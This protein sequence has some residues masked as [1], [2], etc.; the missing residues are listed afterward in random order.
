MMPIFDNW[1]NRRAFWIFAGLVP[2]AVALTFFHPIFAL[3]V[4]P[5]CFYVSYYPLNSI[6][7]FLFQKEFMPPSRV[8]GLPDPA[9]SD[10]LLFLPWIFM[11]IAL[12]F[13]FGKLGDCFFGSSFWHGW[14]SLCD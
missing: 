14:F 3:L 11:F 5:F 12:L 13:F 10:W 4:M 1:P 2:V 6:S 9:W 7:Q 8:P